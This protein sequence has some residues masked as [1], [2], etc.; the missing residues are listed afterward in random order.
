MRGVV[1]GELCFF[2]S[3]SG[4]PIKDSYAYNN[5]KAPREFE[6][7]ALAVLGMTNKEIAKTLFIS[8]ETVKK[9]RLNFKTKA[10]LKDKSLF[11]IREY[12]EKEHGYVFQ[13]NSYIKPGEV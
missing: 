2:A 12:L 13:S 5:S 3:K 8:V 7:M 11:G 9:S 10:N 1:N 4:I 6:I